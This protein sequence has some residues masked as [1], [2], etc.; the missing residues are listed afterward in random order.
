MDVGRTRV[1]AV[2]LLLAG[3]SLRVSPAPARD[4][5]ACMPPALHVHASCACLMRMPHAHAR[6]AGL[7]AV[8]AEQ[9]LDVELLDACRQGDLRKAR[10]L[11]ERGAN[12]NAQSDVGET[13]LHKNPSSLQ[14]NK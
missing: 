11:I 13:P 6:V 4:G 10:G 7:L 5:S 14:S 9:G 2:V 1:L 8:G 3:T 12:V